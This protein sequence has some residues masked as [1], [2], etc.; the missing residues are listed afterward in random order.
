MFGTKRYHRSSDSNTY[1]SR[2]SPTAYETI[3]SENEYFSDSAYEP[4]RQ[5]SY[6]GYPSDDQSN[7]YMSR[8][9]SQHYGMPTYRGEY[10]P[11]PYY[12]SQGPSYSYYDDRNDQPT[13]PLDDLHEEMLQEDEWE[14]QKGFPLNRD[15][16]Y[17]APGTIVGRQQDKLTNAFLRNLI[18]YNNQKEQEYQPAAVAAVNDFG[19]YDDPST[20]F[21]SVNEYYVPQQHQPS[22]LLT[23]HYRQKQHFENAPIREEPFQFEGNYDMRKFPNSHLDEQRETYVPI[24]NQAAED[25]AVLELKSLAKNKQQKSEANKNERRKQNKQQRKQQKQKQQEEERQKQMQLKLEQELFLQQQ[26]VHEQLLKEQQEK[27]QRE[28]EE[29]QR[30]QFQRQQLQQKQQEQ[31]NYFEY[32]L[33]Q[34]NNNDYYMEPEYSDDSWINW[35]RKRSSSDKA[36]E[37]SARRTSAPSGVIAEKNLL[38]LISTTVSPLK[39]SEKFLAARP[40][41]TKPMPLV[42]NHKN[43]HVMEIGDGQ[44]EVVLPRP[45]SP[46]RQ[47]FSAPVLEM[48]THNAIKE[49]DQYES[50]AK[51]SSAYTSLKELL[52]MDE[53]TKKVRVL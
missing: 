16:W 38:Q 34:T 15:S 37:H 26:Q 3:P 36:S 6:D 48:L 10:K 9:D 42:H 18:A 31:P 41:N 23:K 24:D 13:N 19:D 46:V 17:E 28:L 33:E 7:Y 25:E 49:S 35:N 14:R 20:E 51:K 53:K 45:A 47:P 21:D 52:S 32:Q 29:H 4:L 27:Q 22:E 11:K 1:S 40:H 2:H 39:S 44:K 5:P 50:K 8:S 12:Y 43:D 30:E